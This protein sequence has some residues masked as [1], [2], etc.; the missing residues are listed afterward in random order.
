MGNLNLFSLDQLKL[1]DASMLFTEPSSK[2]LRI[3]ITV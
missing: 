1:I 2:T 3:R